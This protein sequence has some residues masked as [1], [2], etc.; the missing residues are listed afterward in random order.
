MELAGTPYRRNRY[1]L[2][3]SSLFGTCGTFCAKTNTCLIEWRKIRLR[4][5]K[6]RCEYVLDGS[7]FN[8]SWIFVE[9]TSGTTT[10]YVKRQEHDFERILQHGNDYTSSTWQITDQKGVSRY[11][12]GVLTNSNSK[13]TYFKLSWRPLYWWIVKIV[14]L[15]CQF[16]Q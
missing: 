2:R 14:Q 10:E 12:F 4:R 7:I 15:E 9:S 6:A 3:C 1:C 8:D 16:G 5:S 11:L 13:L